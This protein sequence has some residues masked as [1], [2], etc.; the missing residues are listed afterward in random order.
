MPDLLVDS[1][2]WV[3]LSF[4]QSMCRPGICTRFES[5]IDNSEQFLLSIKSQLCTHWWVWKFW[6][7]RPSSVANAQQELFWI[8]PWAQQEWVC[9]LIYDA[10]F[11]HL[12]SAAY[13]ELFNMLL[14]IHVACLKG[15]CMRWVCHICWYRN[16]YVCM[17][18]LRGWAHI[19]TCIAHMHSTKRKRC[20]GTIFWVPGIVDHR[21][22]FPLL[23]PH[24]GESNYSWC[25]VLN[26]MHAL[27]IQ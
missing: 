8:I 26:V 1:H 24:V 6:L 4:C 2:I 21:R 27:Y 22:L 14:I 11:F 15:L 17:Y 3:E 18:L 7:W 20:L 10:S 9:I 19:I 12:V 23:C 13:V 16:T 25:L 5:L